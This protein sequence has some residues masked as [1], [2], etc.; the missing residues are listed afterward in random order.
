MIFTKLAESLDKLAGNNAMHAPGGA[1]ALQLYIAINKLEE[2]NKKSPI[3]NVEKQGLKEVSR[4]LDQ[5]QQ[6]IKAL[7]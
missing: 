7:I 3:G 6:K 2:E 1:F 4:T 5:I